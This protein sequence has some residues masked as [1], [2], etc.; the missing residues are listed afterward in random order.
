LTPDKL[1]SPVSDLRI[2]C[3]SNLPVTDSADR[4]S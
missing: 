1:A 4:P 2:C 3:R